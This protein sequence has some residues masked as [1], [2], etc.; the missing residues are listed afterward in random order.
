MVFF[1]MEVIEG[2][3]YKDKRKGIEALIGTLTLSRITV[4][5]WNILK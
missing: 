2:I 3:E 1:E 5:L 4:L